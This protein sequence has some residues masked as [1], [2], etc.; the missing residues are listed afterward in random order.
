MNWIPVTE[1]RPEF[2]E[3][4]V[5]YFSKPDTLWAGK[6]IGIKQSFDYW[7]PVERPKQ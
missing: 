4:I 2:G 7:T 3:L 5:A 6:Y 1:R